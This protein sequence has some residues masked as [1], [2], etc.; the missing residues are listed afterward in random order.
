MFE[1]LSKLVMTYLDPIS[2]VVGLIAAI[3]IFWTW[4]QV[5]FGERRRIRRTYKELREDPGNRPGI[6]IFD[7]L[8]GRNAELQVERFRQNS[9]ELKNVPDERR[10]VFSHEKHV[11]PEDIPELQREIRDAARTIMLQG[12]DR[13]H[14]FYGGPGVLA[15]MIGAEFSNMPVTIYQFETASGTYVNFGPLRLPI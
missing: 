11:T 15:A 5:V 2:V 13:I 8:K 1:A 12:V 3:P 6:I 10:L 4:Y 14:I 7:F 9:E